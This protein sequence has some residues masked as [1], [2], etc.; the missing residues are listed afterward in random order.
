MK[1]RRAI[2]ALSE[3]DQRN[4]TVIVIGVLSAYYVVEYQAAAVLHS[5]L[6][7][8][9]VECV[10]T[11]F[12]ALGILARFDRLTGGRLQAV[13]FA[14]VLMVLTADSIVADS[15]RT[16]GEAIVAAILITTAFVSGRYIRSTP[17]RRSPLLLLAVAVVAMWMILDVGSIAAGVG[18]YDYR[19]YLAGGQH[20]LLGENAYL[21]TPLHQLPGN[22]AND[23]FLYPPVLLPIFGV[24]GSMPFAI[25]A[26]VWIVLLVVAGAIGLRALGISW[27]WL[28]PLLLFPPLVK[29]VTSGNVANLVFAVFSA[30]P[31]LGSVAVLGVLTKVQAG[32]PALWLIRQRRWRDLLVGGVCVLAVCLGTLPLVGLSTWAAFVRGLIVRQESQEFV[33]ALFGSS[34]GQ[35]VPVTIFFAISTLAVAGALRL[36]GRKSLAGLGIASVIAS[37]TLWPHG[38]LMALPAALALPAPVLWLVLGTATGGA[39]L[40]ILPVAGICGLL[41]QWMQAERDDELHPLGNRGVGPWQ[42]TEIEVPADG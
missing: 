3:G 19:V 1:M 22:P 27:L 28:P 17:Y 6:L 38:F 16:L 33:P 40:W 9:W 24:V 14:V 4:A 32:I 18:L 20:W 10:A 21:Q 26:P 23:F 30:T 25:S 13:T 12:V 31:L 37:P 5:P 7:W 39:S 2:R 36:D 8:L 35:Y 15:R 42:T 11:F 29:G 34:L 41:R